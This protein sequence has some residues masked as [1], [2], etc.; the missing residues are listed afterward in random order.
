MGHTLVL[1]ADYSPVS[2]LPLSTLNWQD[3]IKAVYLE[4]VSVIHEYD[5]WRVNSP[6]CSYGVPA[7]VV[8]KRHIKVRRVLS[9]GARMAE[10]I[11]LR[12]GYQCQYCNLRFGSN[13]L[14]LD[15][16]VPKSHGGKFHVTNLVAACQDCNSRR[17]NNTKIQPRR[18]P[19]KP[20]YHELAAKSREFPLVIPH[21]AWV[22]YIGWSHDLLSVKA[23]DGEPGYDRS[24]PEVMLNSLLLNTELQ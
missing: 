4:T 18:Q 6:S 2:V 15:H 14:T 19:Y 23:P 16:V 9:V 10:V 1:N 20:T 21:P 11:F 12:D 22:D 7:V 3:A 24:E 8:T 17:G 5:N 13:K